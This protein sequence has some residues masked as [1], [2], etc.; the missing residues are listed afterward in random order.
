MKKKI[1]YIV[2][3]LIVIAIV[4]AVLIT[5]FGRITRDIDISQAVS[6]SGTGCVDNDCTDSVNIS[7]GEK[8][9]SEEYTLTS[10]TSV[11]APIELKNFIDPSDSG[12]VIENIYIC[13]QNSSVFITGADAGLNEVNDLHNV[14]FEDTSAGIILYYDGNEMQFNTTTLTESN[15]N[16][17]KSTNGTD[18]VI[19]L[20]FITL[21]NR[22]D[23]KNIIIN[24]VPTEL[25]TILPGEILKFYTET[26]FQLGHV[27]TYQMIT[28]VDIR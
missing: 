3:G 1:L 5:Y 2:S 13:D 16:G 10:I 23:I 14:S 12:I 19:G 18:A 11:N 27:G 22:S 21:D 26:Q 15:L 17:L 9:I 25:L 28:Q 20:R 4:S 8:F 6:L 7:G 24:S